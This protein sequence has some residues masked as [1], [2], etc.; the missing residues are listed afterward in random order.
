MKTKAIGNRAHRG[1]PVSRECIDTNAG[2]VADLHLL[3][4]RDERSASDYLKVPVKTLRNWRSSGEGP[5]FRKLGAL[6]RYDRADLDAFAN[7]VVK[8]GGAPRSE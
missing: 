2:G 5:R 8:G 4:L 1:T 6:V 3:D 7:R